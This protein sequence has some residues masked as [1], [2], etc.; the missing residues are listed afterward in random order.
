MTTSSNHDALI[1]KL[2]TLAEHA[3]VFDAWAHHSTADLLQ[4]LRMTRETADSALTNAVR[5]ARAEGMSWDAIGR[6]LNVSKQAAQ[7]RYG[8]P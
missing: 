3:Q 8:Q 7:Q 4:T 1:A 2:D 6:W 5:E